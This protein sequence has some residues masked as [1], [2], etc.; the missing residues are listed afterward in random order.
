VIVA[1]TLA[2]ISSH[3]GIEGD[4]FSA[5]VTEDVRAANGQVVIP[6][7]SS[8]HGRIT[9]VSSPSGPRSK[10]TLTLALNTL[11]VAGKTYLLYASFDSL[12]TVS[13]RHDVENGA[14]TGT[15]A[16]APLSAVLEGAD[17]ILPEGSHLMLT[18]SRPL[19]VAVE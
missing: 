13:E 9:D 19:S 15:G 2:Q 8:V 10:G 11:R 12:A 16:D 14:I 18:L 7:G 4:P 6:A 5:R 1:T 3:H 17:V